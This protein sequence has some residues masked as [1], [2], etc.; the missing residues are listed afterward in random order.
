MTSMPKGRGAGFDHLDVLR[1]AVS[2]DKEGAGRFDLAHTL[3]HGHRFGAGSGLVQQ[4]RIGN[5]KPG[6]IADHGLIVQQRLK[7]ALS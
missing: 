4:R 1:V 5:L 3:R 2:V 6:Q 7:P